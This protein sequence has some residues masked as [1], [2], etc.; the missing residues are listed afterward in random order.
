MANPVPNKSLEIA[1]PFQSWRRYLQIYRENGENNGI[2]TNF[3]RVADGTGLPSALA[4]S[5]GA[6]QVLGTAYASLFSGNGS[7]LNNLQWAS[8]VGTPTTVI[9]YGLTELPWSMVTGRP[10]TIAG[11]GISDLP[12]ANVTGRPTTIAGYGITDNTWTNLL[13]KPTTIAGFGITDNTWA[14]IL[15]KPT[16]IA[17]FGITDNTWANLLSK[18][19]TVAGLGITELTTHVNSTSN[20]HSVT[21]SQ[22]G[23]GNVDNTSDANK[24][25][26]TATQ[27]ALNLKADASALSAHTS[28][29]SNPHSVTKSQVG[30]GNVDNTSDANKPV[31]TAT[32]TALNLKLNSADFT[33]PNIGSKP[34]T[35]SGF[36]ITDAPETDGNGHIKREYFGPTSTRF[37]YVDLDNGDD[38]T[39]QRANQFRPFLTGQAAEAVAQAGDTIVFLPGDY[40][41]QAPLSGVDQVHYTGFSTSVIPSFVI[42]QGPDITVSGVVHSL[43]IQDTVENDSAALDFSQ[44][45]INEDVEIHRGVLNLGEVKKTLQ[46]YGGEISVKKAGGIALRQDTVVK[47]SEAVGL[48]STPLLDAAVTLENS[49]SGTCVLQGRVET[50]GT[51]SAGVLIKDSSSGS[52]YLKNLDIISEGLSV[53]ASSSKTVRVQG[54]VN[55]TTAPSSDI[56]LVG[57]GYFNVSSD[58]I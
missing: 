44:A 9:D 19:T 51:H 26:S 33:W 5:T 54:I 55:V 52:L 15:S 3:E 23:L 18:P 58:F 57:V 13:S 42:S 47:V 32:Q 11:Y 28:N 1:A 4:I 43:I 36:G 38:A 17:G 12:W 39:G 50:E 30:L 40:S 35:V 53:E 45:I 25:V 21:K 29:T 31:S 2:H 20:P 48:F 22:V 41:S 7:A 8:I 6:V 10:T 14:N 27:T 56:N 24:P 16:T 37:I 46:T 34:T 49:F